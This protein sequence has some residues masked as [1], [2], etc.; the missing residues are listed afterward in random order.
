MRYP[1]AKNLF[2]S[3]FGH[4]YFLSNESNLGSPELICKTCNQR[5]TYNNNDIIT[6][7]AE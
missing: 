6:V 5:F 7:I 4:N 3:T 1:S 2:C